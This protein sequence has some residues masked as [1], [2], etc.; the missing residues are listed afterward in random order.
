MEKSNHVQFGRFRPTTLSSS[1]HGAGKQP[2]IIGILKIAAEY[3][4]KRHSYYILKLARA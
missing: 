1:N 3:L 4:I 2:D